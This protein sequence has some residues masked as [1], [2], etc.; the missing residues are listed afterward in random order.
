M[1]DSTLSSIRPEWPSF[2]ILFLL[3]GLMQLVRWQ[4]TGS[5]PKANTPCTPL[6]K[7]V[8]VYKPSKTQDGYNLTVDNC[9][10]YDML[11]RFIIKFPGTQCALYKDG[12]IASWIKNYLVRYK[13]HPRTILWKRKLHVH[14]DIHIAKDGT[15]WTLG[16]AKH[17]FL[18]QEVRF[19]TLEQYR[20][21]GKRLFYWSSYEKRMEII[22]LLGLQTLLKQ[23]AEELF[24]VKDHENLAMRVYNKGML[25]EPNQQDKLALNVEWGFLHMNSVAPLPPNPFESKNP[26]FRR[27]NIISSFNHY[28]VLFILDRNTRKIVWSWWHGHRNG[29][30]QHSV[31]MLPNGLIALFSNNKADPKTGELVNYS[32]VTVIHPISKKV[33]WEYKGSPTTKMRTDLM[34][35]F[36]RLSNGNYLITAGVKALA[37]EVTPDKKVVWEWKMPTEGHKISRVSRKTVERLMKQLKRKL[38]VQTTV[39]YCSGS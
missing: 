18:G 3:F 6:P 16:Y 17:K 12:T 35:A 15:L 30:G 5:H 28:N 2:A 29:L 33:L 14:N 22:R 37:L 24:A 10:I 9:R 32:S 31:R 7:T 26:A 11:G 23:P 19:D 1:S 13:V 34:G 25:F 38:P 20:K 21:D 39:K 27:G 8:S 36:Q 4:E